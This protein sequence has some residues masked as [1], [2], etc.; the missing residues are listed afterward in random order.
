M[1]IPPLSDA[2]LRLAAVTTGR[3]LT[4][5]CAPPGSGYRIG[6]DRDEDGFLDGDARAAGSDPADPSDTP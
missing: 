2:L 1:A 4:Y 3:A 5:T 6:V